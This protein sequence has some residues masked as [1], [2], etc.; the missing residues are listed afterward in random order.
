LA[1]LLA[2]VFVAV[3]AAKLA[4]AQAMVAIFEKVGIGQWF[5]FL[6]GTLEV[7]GGIGVL[8]PSLRFPAAILLCF[9]MLGAIG[10]QVFYGA[11]RKSS[12]SNCSPDPKRRYCMAGASKRLQIHGQGLA[13]DK[14]R[15]TKTDRQWSSA[16]HRNQAR[17]RDWVSRLSVPIQ[18][19]YSFGSAGHPRRF[20]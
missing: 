11:R 7:V 8:I 4:G 5:R 9:I 2:L 1:V 20:Y 3:G 18:D 10:S 6:T 12:S 14:L 19:A 17:Y 13:H 16:A 15:L